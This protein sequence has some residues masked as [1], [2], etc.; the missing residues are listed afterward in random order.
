MVVGEEHDEE[1]DEEPADDDEEVEHL[2][3]EEE[4]DKRWKGLNSW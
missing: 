3:A 2:E 1:C 4:L